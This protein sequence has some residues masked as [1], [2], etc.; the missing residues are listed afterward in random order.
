MSNKSNTEVWRNDIFL[1]FM[2]PDVRRVAGAYKKFNHSQHIKGILHGIKVA[3]LLG[4]RLILPPSFILQCPFVRNALEQC[5]ALLRNRVIIFPMRESN[6]YDFQEKKERQYHSVRKH[7]K[8]IHENLGFEILKKYP[9]LFTQ[10][11]LYM[12]K[13]IARLWRES[14][15]PTIKWDVL[16]EAI[17]KKYDSLRELP[18]LLIE[19]DIAVTA[20]AIQNLFI[21]D[22]ILGLR[23]QI[24]L[25][26]QGIYG[27]IYIENFNAVSITG[28]PILPMNFGLPD[29]GSAYNYNVFFDLLNALGL[30]KVLLSQSLE[31]ISLLR[32]RHGYLKFLKSYILLSKQNTKS[33]LIL[34]FTNKYYNKKLLNNILLFAARKGMHIGMIGNL[35]IDVLDDIFSEIS[36]HISLEHVTNIKKQP[37]NTSIQLS[38][39][40]EN[41]NSQPI[42]KKTNN[43]NSL[44]FS[45]LKNNQDTYINRKRK[46][47]VLVFSAL[48]EELDFLI[49]D[50]TGHQDS[51]A[52]KFAWKY[53][54]KNMYYESLFELSSDESI[55][56]FAASADEA[57]I[58][59]TAI[60]ATKILPLIE[61][62][63]A[64]MI[65]ICG[66]RKSEEVE[67]ADIIIPT[68]SF[69]YSYGA[70]KNGKLIP[71]IRNE[72]IDERINAWA[73]NILT[74]VKIRALH[75]LFPEGINRPRSF[76]RIKTGPMGCGDLIVKDISILDDAAELDRKLIGV[77]M[78]SYAFIRAA[79]QGLSSKGR[80]LVLKSVSDFADENKDDKYRD[81]CKYITAACALDL[82]KN[83]QNSPFYVSG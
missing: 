34:Y 37:S 31:T 78:E 81:Y 71:E 68:Q 70:Y 73:K 22:E 19:N 17:P 35:F 6:P 61:P 3:A 36:D 58:T 64:I 41:Y 12:G 67:L 4:D 20:P 15:S 52:K 38:C 30:F 14:D 47:R 77:D 44:Q 1:D 42:A 16:Q 26:L 48:S 27:N 43:P 62:D 83:L 50:K 18:K 5:H 49:N 7:Y 45:S 57:G 75:E 23:D 11:D 54:S 28:L 53:N 82:I 65:G 2:N 76:P 39:L 51:I 8:D 24:D 33:D 69:L 56:I 13:T 66:G 59:P 80:V 32:L 25:I 63:L 60:L 55:E 79:R 40:E 21:G 72:I 46:M 29:S 9:E 10:R 74:S